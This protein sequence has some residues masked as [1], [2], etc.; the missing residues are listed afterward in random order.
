MCFENG[1]TRDLTVVMKADGMDVSCGEIGL[2]DAIRRGNRYIQCL[3]KIFSS[4][5]VISAP[6]QFVDDLYIEEACGLACQFFSAQNEACAESQ[7]QWILYFGRLLA[8]QN[9]AECFQSMVNDYDP[10]TMTGLHPMCEQ[11]GATCVDKED[12][13]GRNLYC[14]M[15]KGGGWYGNDCSTNGEGVYNDGPEYD[16]MGDVE[17]NPIKTCEEEFALHP[18]EKVGE[19]YLGCASADC[20]VRGLEMCEDRLFGNFL[21]Q[22]T[23]GKSTGATHTN[24]GL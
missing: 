10:Y 5:I 20:G 6:D 23:I 22:L 21:S 24:Y 13:W 1:C 19:K 12:C 18:G 8:S 4:D 2:D 9:A 3:T 17:N 14:I 11:P 15:Y 7:L 16:L